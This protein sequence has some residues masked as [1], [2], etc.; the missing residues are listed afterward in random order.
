MLNATSDL[1][2][3]ALMQGA[4]PAGVI[5]KLEEIFASHYKELQSGNGNGT[6]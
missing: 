3:T 6:E 2:A 1:V 5:D 4:E